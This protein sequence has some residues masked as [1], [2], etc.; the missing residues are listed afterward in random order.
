MLIFLIHNALKILFF[1]FFNDP[2]TT[3]IYTLSLHDALPILYLILLFLDMVVWFESLESGFLVYGVG[4]YDV[5]LSGFC[6]V[7]ALYRNVDNPGNQNG[8]E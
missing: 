3:E 7:G 5:G 8:A 1:F 4:V 6:G 2:A